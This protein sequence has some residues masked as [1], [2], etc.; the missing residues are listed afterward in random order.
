VEEKNGGGKVVWACILFLV[1]TQFFFFQLPAAAASCKAIS[2]EQTHFFFGPCKLIVGPQGMRLEDKGPLNFTLV[3]KSPT[4]QV[5]VFRND[6][7][8][9]FTQS[10]SDFVRTGLVS[11][12][13]LS[14]NTKY[15]GGKNRR[16]TFVLSNKTIERLT[17]SDQTLKVLP[18]NNLPVPIECIIHAAYKLPTNGGILIEFTRTLRDSDLVTGMRNQGRRQETLSTKKIEDIDV[19]S[20]IYD[21]PAAY[22]RANSMR[23]VV[24]GKS[25]RNGAAFEELL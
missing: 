16:S 14:R 6:D 3:A 25:T 18:L 13:V 17:G 5:T 19:S 10:L 2:L 20:T 15:I 24:T 1:A 22:S 11:D 4:W 7:K 8:V 21:P 23:E 9:Y 12:L